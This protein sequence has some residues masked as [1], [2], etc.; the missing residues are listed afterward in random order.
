MDVHRLR[1]GLPL[2]LG[3]VDIP[4]KH[5][6][7][8]HSDADVVVHAIIDAILGAAAMRDIGFHFPDTDPQYKGIS[9]L[10]LLE[11]TMQII[12]Q[13]NWKIGN[14]DA[15]IVLQSPKISSYIPEMQQNIARIVHSDAINIKATT[16]EKLGFAGREEGIQAFAVVMLFR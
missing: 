14:I 9:S 2:V 4:A 15:T 6:A 7:V 13:Q 10:L 16:T 5:G 12:R 3:G 8:G 11:H 1:E